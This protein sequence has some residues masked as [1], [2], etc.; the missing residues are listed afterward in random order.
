[1]VRTH[2]P[3]GKNVLVTVMEV[4]SYDETR[5]GESESL[6]KHDAELEETK[7]MI[8]ALKSGAPR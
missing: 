7:R 8:E 2:T 1:M 5:R 3:T 6:Q 4:P